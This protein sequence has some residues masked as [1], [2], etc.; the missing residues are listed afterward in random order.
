MLPAAT[1]GCSGGRL[2]IV[3]CPGGALELY[4]IEAETTLGPPRGRVKGDAEKSGGL[5]GRVGRD[6]AGAVDPAGAETA[7]GRP[8]RRRGCGRVEWIAGADAAGRGGPNASGR[9]CEVAQQVER[10]A[11]VVGGTDGEP[12]N[13]RKGGRW[14]DDRRNE[15]RPHQEVWTGARSPPP[16]SGTG[17]GRAARGFRRRLVAGRCTRPGQPRR[18]RSETVSAQ[19]VVAG[20]S[21]RSVALLGSITV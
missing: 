14:R 21:R 13:V 11:R 1:G 8:L 10:F 6:P 3:R 12:D 5:R 17:R 4:D 15:A 19:C 18:R 7:G 2:G 16:T 20:R 9:G